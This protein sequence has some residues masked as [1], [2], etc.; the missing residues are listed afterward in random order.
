MHP[1]LQSGPGIQPAA[2]IEPLSLQSHRLTLYPLSHIMFYFIKYSGLEVTLNFYFVDGLK[3][4]IL[5]EVPGHTLHLLVPRREIHGV[6]YAG[7]YTCWLHGFHI[8][9]WD[10]DLQGFECDLV[11]E[12]DADPRTILHC[13]K[14]SGSLLESFNW[15]NKDHIKRKS[16]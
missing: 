11:L 7:S 8:K 2:G 9:L 4:D 5:M 14:D 16:V 1:S 3:W 15:N 6:I 10:L 13:G 12:M